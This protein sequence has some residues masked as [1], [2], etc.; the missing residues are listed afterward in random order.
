MNKSEVR[1]I[2]PHISKGEV[3]LNHA[4]ISPLSDQVKL[5]IKNF[6]TNRNSGQI[7]NFEEWMGLVE[8]TR[9]LI[10]RLIHTDSP[11]RISFMGNTSDA[12]SAVAEGMD[13][14]EGDEIILNTLEFP[15]NIQP[16]RILEN[17]GVKLV[18][19]QPDDEGRITSDMIGDSITPNTK[20]VSISAVQYLNGF[21]AD[22]KS[23]GQICEANDLF[24]VVDGIQALGAVNLDVQECKIDALA[25]GAHKWLMSPMGIGFLYLS[26]KMSQNLHPVKTGWLSVKEP[27]ELAN[28]NQQWKSISK[29]LETGTYNMSGIIGLHASL[30]H[31]LEIGINQIQKEILKLTQFL[32]TNVSSREDVTIITPNS[33]DDHAGI[34]SFSIENDSNAEA[35]VKDLKSKQITISVRQGHF[36]ISPH[37]Y[38]TEDELDNVLSS[39]FR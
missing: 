37:Y 32:F 14:N 25:S 17:K 24:F 26:E 18:Y 21:R 10:S 11:E 9:L 39:I 6:L 7:D 38:N 1:K 3:Y 35:I 15:S 2:F 29:H 33:P 31:L 23:I 5:S 8:E 34:F 22:L 16:F 28:F 12:L 27:F 13:W 20:M 36:R 19:L 4:A 30:I